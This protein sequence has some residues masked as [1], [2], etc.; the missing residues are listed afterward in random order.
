MWLLLCGDF[1]NREERFY[2]FFFFSLRKIKGHSQ[3]IYIYVQAV[4]SII[5]LA[6]H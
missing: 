6:P 3:K 2:I 4:F 1:I 5:F